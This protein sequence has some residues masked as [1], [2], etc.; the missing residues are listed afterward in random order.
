MSKE[1]LKSIWKQ[2]VVSFLIYRSTSIITIVLAT[3]FL[4]I[5]LLVGKIYFSYGSVNGWTSK[6]YY[7]LITFMNSATNLY[8]LFF[9]IGHENLAEDILEG[10]LDYIFVR[11]VSSY[12]YAVMGELDL[13]SVFNLLLSGGLMAHYLME[14][15]IAGWNCFLIVVMVF[16]TAALIFLLNQ[17][18]ISLNLW[19]D[20]LSALAGIV[21]DVVGWASRPRQIFPKVIQQLFLFVVP[22]LMASNL[23]EEVVIRQKNYW[24]LGYYVLFLAGLYL[25][26]KWVWKKG[27]KR[28]S[29][30]N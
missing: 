26:S 21:E 2:S 12:W 13:P 15:Q 3:V 17:I 28:Y 9:I 25:F 5:E 7:I 20:G 24:M 22:V 11:P 14:G 4:V 30:A 8:N 6:D 10:E 29:S 19:F 16:L 23:P 1:V 18:V 27:T